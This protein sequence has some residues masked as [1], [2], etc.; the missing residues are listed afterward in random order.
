MNDGKQI[1]LCHASEDKAAIRHLYHQLREARFTPW[2]DEE[3]LLPGEDWE[4]EIRE[5]VKRSVTVLVCLSAASITKRGFVQKEIRLALDV[6]DE[7]PSGSIFVVPVKLMPCTIPERL[8]R[9][10]YVELYHP[11]GFHRL[12]KALAKVVTPQVEFSS[13]RT[14]PEVG[15]HNKLRYCGPDKTVRFWASMKGDSRFTRE[16]QVERG[17]NL[18]LQAIWAGD[19][20]ELILGSSMSMDE[21]TSRMYYAFFENYTLDRPYAKKTDLDGLSQAQWLFEVDAALLG[22]DRT[23]DSLR[24]LIQSHHDEIMRIRQRKF[25][26]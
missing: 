14:S 16:L 18:V 17:S 4:S 23:E 2:L 11:R 8:A 22:Q 6:A 20:V 24:E 25:D 19:D 21:Q 9:W 26:Q 10:Q 1:F 7:L 12:V 3:D 15:A 5:A 13:T